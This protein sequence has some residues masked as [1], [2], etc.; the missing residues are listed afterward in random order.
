M[1]AVVFRA[2]LRD[3]SLRPTH[4]LMVDEMREL[5]ESIDDFVEWR[6]ALDGLAYWGYVMFESAASTL[7]W[8]AHPR[9]AEIHGRAERAVYSEFAVRVFEEVRGSSW[10]RE[11]SDTR[12]A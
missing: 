11:P 2:T 1:H 7:A 10:E 5:A 6:D 9:H 3:H 12:G 4:D 8:K